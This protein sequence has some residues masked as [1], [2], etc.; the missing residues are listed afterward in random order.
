[1][2]QPSLLTAV[3]ICLMLATPGA[4]AAE[5]LELQTIMK[6]LGKHM[7]NVTD[8]ISR[9]DWEIVAR[10]A[11]LIADH[12]QPPLTEKMRIMAFMGSDMA[13]FKAFDGT[14]HDAAAEMGRF[15]QEKNGQKV[16]DSFHKLQSACLGCH[17]T[18]R[19]PFVDYF[20]GKPGN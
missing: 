12:P 20:Y 3:I 1:M 4:Q 18:F 15:A 11:P 9:E 17:Q 16:I 8:G 5:P 14:T 6:D 7:Q 2:N 10:A 19:K 13:K